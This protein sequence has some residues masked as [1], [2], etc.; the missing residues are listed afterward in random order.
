MRNEI[1]EM[2]KVI[3]RKVK[4]SRYLYAMILLFYTYLPI[5]LQGLIKRTKKRLGELK[6]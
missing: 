3:P 4:I 5:S 6:K 2:E 1:P